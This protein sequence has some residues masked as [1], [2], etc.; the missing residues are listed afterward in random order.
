MAG[1]YKRAHLSAIRFWASLPQI[2]ARRRFGR[3]RP[4]SR[5][6]RSPEPPQRSLRPISHFQSGSAR[7]RPSRPIHDS[8][9]GP[10]RRFRHRPR[11]T[12]TAVRR[13]FLTCAEPGT[14][15][16]LPSHGIDVD[17]LALHQVLG[18]TFAFELRSAPRAL[19][20]LPN[21][22]RE[23]EVLLPMPPP[24]RHHQTFWPTQSRRDRERLG[25]LRHRA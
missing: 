4:R 8:S 22:F 23:R 9:Q 18:V 5:E 1:R 3:N 12:K 6:D 15:Q 25:A 17:W 21:T 16:E 20:A 7:R 11:A 10:N 14:R 19:R 24:G 13:D 2:D